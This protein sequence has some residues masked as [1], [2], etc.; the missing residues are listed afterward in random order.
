M[1]LKYQ[2]MSREQETVI[3]LC[4]GASLGAYIPAL[5]AH[6]QLSDR[7]IAS[8]VVVLENILLEKKRNNVLETKFA[9][10]RNFSFA[11]M[12]QKLTKDIT[13]SLDPNLVSHLLATWRQQKCRRFMIFSGFWLPIANQYLQETEGQDIAIDL[14]H[15]DAS[16]STSWKMYDTTHPAFRHVWFFNWENKC[17]GYNF[18]VSDDEPV[19][20]RQRSNRFLIHGGGWGVGTYK[21]KIPELVQQGIN[22]DIIAYEPQDLENKPDH[23]RYFLIDPTWKPW[24]KDAQGYHQFPP[25]GEV[26]DQDNI[27][28]QSSQ[29]YPEVYSLIGQSRGIISKPGGGTLVDSLSSAT[30]LVWLA[31]YGDYENNNGLLWE[32]LGFGISYEKWAHSSY[33]LDILEKLH[34]NLKRARSG[35]PR[36]ITHYIETYLNKS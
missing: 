12:A 35:L 1:S 24:E 21:S 8:E 18:S 33:S 2:R 7:G 22:L 32:Y 29:P 4:S 14:C 36:Y 27:T 16:V 11:L 3:I 13:P 31:P 25:F 23:S 34:T 17:L 26:K 28:F 30:P 10:H 6:H 5:I 20:Y 9:F 19:P 15:M